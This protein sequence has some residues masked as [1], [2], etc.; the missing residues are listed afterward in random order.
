MFTAPAPLGSIIGGVLAT[1]SGLRATLWFA[2]IG[3][4][5]CALPLILSP[6]RSLRDDAVEP[7]PTLRGAAVD[8]EATT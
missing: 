6:F 5:T 1:A 3:T 4:V 2:G 8:A 7:P